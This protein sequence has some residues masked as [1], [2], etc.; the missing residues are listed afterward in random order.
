MDLLFPIRHPKWFVKG[1]LLPEIYKKKKKKKK[2][3]LS[4]KSLDHIIA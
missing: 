1:F 3:A 2:K 4:L